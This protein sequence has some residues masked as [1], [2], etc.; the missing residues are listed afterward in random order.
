[1]TAQLRIL[2]FLTAASLSTA[3][4]CAQQTPGEQAIVAAANKLNA[5]APQD[6][7]NQTIMLGT[8]N[9]ATKTFVWALPDIYPAGLP[10]F[11]EVGHGGDVQPMHEPQIKS[12]NMTYEIAV[13]NIPEGTT[14]TLSIPQADGST[15]ALPMTVNGNT[16]K[17]S[18]RALLAGVQM[19]SVTDKAGTVVQAMQLVPII[20]P[21]LGGFVV[22][23]L[24]L[25]IIYAPP[26]SLSTATY[27]QTSTAGTTM[28]WGFSESL[29]DVDTEDLNST[30]TLA[31]TLAPAIPDAGDAAAAVIGVAETETTVT[32]N[33]TTTGTTQSDSTSIGLTQSFGIPANAANFPGKG[34]QFVILH[35]VLFMYV[36]DPSTGKV[37]LACVGY[38]NVTSETI[39]SLPNVV[40][41]AAATQILALDP[42]LPSQNQPTRLLAV[43][44]ANLDP[45]LFN[46]GTPAATLY[47]GRFKYITSA[48]MDTTTNTGV[49]L[50]LSDLVTTTKSTVTSQTVVTNVGGLVESVEGTP[51][52][53]YAFTY[54]NSNAQWASQTTTPQVVLTA[55]QDSEDC[56]V[57]CYYDTI[58]GSIMCLKGQ[59]ITENDRKA[60]TTGK[61]TDENGKPLAN[62]AAIFKIGGRSYQVNTDSDGNFSFP[63]ASLPAG[64]G[65]VTVGDYL[66]NIESTG[67]PLTGLNLSPGAPG[68]EKIAPAHN[69][70]AV[71]APSGYDIAPIPDAKGRLGKVAVTFPK[72]S[73]P[74]NTR[75]DIYT[76]S[77]DQSIGGAYGDS[78]IELLPGDYDVSICTVRVPVKV[79][80][81]SQTNLAVGILSV[82]AGSNTRVSISGADPKTEIYGAYGEFQIGLPVGTYK[83]TVAGQSDTATVKAG[84]ITDF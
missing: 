5:A 74:G 36:F 6:I 47:G 64:T 48:K 41:Q 72:G 40:G 76:P 50:T 63:I 12:L 78:S 51:S 23:N 73:S 59:A 53:M 81:R 75:I 69:Q 52:D 10:V 68:V 45:T 14:L 27:A 19:V 46:T 71:A 42:M 66:Q 70:I 2:A 43:D 79:V 61:A 1:M 20:A 62:K 32:T 21:Q 77:S 9:G 18:F 24:L 84:Q 22:P 8:Y 55:G 17:V 54:S 65:T 3:W 26:G 58:F 7:P 16:A 82:H 60:Q 30:V 49:G 28:T 13:S 11:K 38:A 57:N 67:Q 4:A 56:W 25:S 80:S 34:D 83:V 15:K 35:D 44:A 37:T 33:Q 29:G 31:K 39:S